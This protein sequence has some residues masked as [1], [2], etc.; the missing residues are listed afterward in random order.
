MMTL[1]LLLLS[2][3]TPGVPEE[4]VWPI[5]GTLARP[6]GTELRISAARVERRWDA[7][8]GRFREELSVESRGAAGAVVERKSFQARL[9]K[10]PPGIYHVVL[11]EEDR[12]LS[13]ERIPLGPPGEVP[14]SWASVPAKLAASRDRLQEFLRTAQ[15]VAR[16]EL[17]ANPTQEKAYT[18]GLANEERTLA[19]LALKSDFTA[20][21]AFLGRIGE[22]LRNAQLWGAR[23]ADDGAGSFLEDGVTFDSLDKA[24][25]AA[26]AVLAAELKSS[27]ASFLAL[28]TARAADRP[29]LLAPLQDAARKAVG[30]LQGAPPDFLEAVEATSQADV[31]GLPELR[32]RLEAFRDALVEAPSK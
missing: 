31:E 23:P 27:I 28:L 13:A 6:D 4:R 3:L 24:L 16:G 1:T 2:Q 30:A 8:S 12:E 20:T 26:P 25:A 10:G 15:K 5:G 7:R 14:A 21:A 9:R 29:K 22:L 18:A 17:P 32:R 19:E 11:R